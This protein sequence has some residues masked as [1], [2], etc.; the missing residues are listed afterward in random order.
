MTTTHAD[1]P[2]H[3]DVAA[4]EIIAALNTFLRHARVPNPAGGPDLPW[5]SEIR[6][7]AAT[8]T[9][10]KTGKTYT[11]V[12]AAWFDRTG[13]EDIA[14]E[15]AS[16]WCQPPD[17]LRGYPESRFDPRIPVGTGV[18]PFAQPPIPRCVSPTRPT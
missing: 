14:I 3:V 17:R 16:Q 11:N 4:D 1:I 18:H 8:E 9:N 2:E 12:E 13:I 15:L 7:P 5:V 6:I 10:P